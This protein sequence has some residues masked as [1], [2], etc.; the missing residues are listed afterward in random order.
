MNDQAHT[1]DPETPPMP[2][3]AAHQPY[4]WW[5][6]VLGMALVVAFGVMAVHGTGSGPQAANADAG[7]TSGVHTSETQV[8]PIDLYDDE[9]GA[10]G[11]STPPESHPSLERQDLFASSPR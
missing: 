3:R 2:L 8:T 7:R 10:H 4:G 9:A 1:H 6:S 11:P 5:G